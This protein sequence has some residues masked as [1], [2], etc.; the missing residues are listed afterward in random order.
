MTTANKAKWNN[1]AEM[2][3]MGFT[4][5]VE[6]EEHCKHLIDYVLKVLESS[7]NAEEVFKEAHK[8]NSENTP[9]SHFAISGTQFGT[10]MTFVRD[11]EMTD[12][13][14]DDGVLAYVYNLDCPD[15]SE[16]GYV[17]FKNRNGKL[18]RYA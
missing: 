9:I 13:T 2:S 8:Y 14:T 1:D 16:L 17:F 12:I 18:V 7:A 6:N 5:P 3:L 4:I 11:E 10:L 15:C